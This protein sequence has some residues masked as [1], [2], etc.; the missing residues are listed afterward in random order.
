MVE[1][2]FLGLD[3]TVQILFV[4]YSRKDKMSRVEACSY[5]TFIEVTV[6]TIIGEIR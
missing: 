6:T 2:I 5:W 4:K 3:A 1:P